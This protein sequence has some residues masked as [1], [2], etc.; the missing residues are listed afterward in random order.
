ML[1]MFLPQLRVLNCEMGLAEAP[2]TG[3]NGVAHSRCHKTVIVTK[4][5]SATC[6][7][8]LGGRPQ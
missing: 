6:R 1:G 2:K 4:A 3:V 7:N 5:E 8:D